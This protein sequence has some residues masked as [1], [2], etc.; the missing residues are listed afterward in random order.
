MARVADEINRMEA[1]NNAQN[2]WG[3]ISDLREQGFKDTPQ[4]RE[5]LI[6]QIR[7]KM[8]RH[9]QGKEDSLMVIVDHILTPEPAEDE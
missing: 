5:M 1:L 4:V 6:D 8:E 3:F 9:T 2:F 7:P